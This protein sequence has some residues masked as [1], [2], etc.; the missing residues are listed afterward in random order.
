MFR[1]AFIKL[2]LAVSLAFSSF[3]QESDSLLLL[4]DKANGID[5]VNI[6]HQLIL[7]EWLNYPNQAM[8]HGHEALTISGEFND[9]VNISKSLRLIA[10]VHYYK[11]DF[12]TSLDYNQRALDMALSIG[13]ST[14]INNGYN[15]IGLIYYDLGSYQTSLEYL[16]R[17]KAIKD[18]TGDRYGLGATL[19]NI[20]LVFERV[21]DFE[22]ARS[23]FFEAYDAALMNNNPDVKVY[24]LNNIG[25]TFRKE[26]NF[27]LARQYFDSALTLARKIGNINWGAVSLRNIGEILRYEGR[28][29][30]ASSYYLKSLQACQEIG[31]KKGQAESFAFLAKHA[32]DLGQIE[33]ATE[34]LDRSHEIA[35]RTKLRYQLLENLRLY[36]S[37]H[38]V[39]KDNYQ[40]I[41]NQFLYLDL[42][43]S[44]FQDA[45][46]RN[47]SL[48]PIKIKEEED[49]IKLLKQQADL[50]NKSF[51][52]RIYVAV[53]IGAVPLFSLLIIL[54]RRNVIAFR[55]LR[56]NND[57]LK[58]TQN[59]L[60]RSEKMASL[61][62]LAAGVG[63]EI[64]NPLN[65]IKNGVNTMAKK[66]QKDYKE[67]RNSLS[68]YFDIIDE[69][70]DR[71]S[72]IVKSLSHFSRSGVNGNEYC[73]VEDIIENCL[74]ILG[75]KLRKIDVK[76]N[77]V[78]K[79]IVVKGSEGK[80]HQAFMNIISNAQQSISGRGSIEVLTEVN[81][82]KLVVSIKDDG[83]GIPK[84]NLL[85]M[86]D[87]FFTTKPPGEGTGLGLFI[88]YSIIEEHYGSIQVI[89]EENVGTQFIVTLP[90]NNQS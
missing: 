51:T 24:S 12:D 60:I 26:G 49:R 32:L 58:R 34:F 40:V 75:N 41:R 29:D 89:S 62:V 18:N 8:G 27:Q 17:S 68:T 43:D 56:K 21:S 64:N 63:H 44:L 47:L 20:G 57:E 82:G 53:L 25:I 71:A 42:S 9:S 74:L 78:T 55:E 86:G 72:Q 87:P 59:L 38:L 39:N 35:G 33:Q 50:R 52:N 37:I 1:K 69:G 11:G 46:G 77:Y 80:L 73:K 45:V 48:V 4:L 14:L 13:D 84:E 16:L 22:T 81:D 70:V 61:G 15:N 90:L 5:R 85:K 10:G 31:D 2:T 66:M 7:S 88:T 83:V 28:Y 54:F 67:A 65:Y 6:L 3:G 76:R 36:A 30:S 23:N 79:P 19:N